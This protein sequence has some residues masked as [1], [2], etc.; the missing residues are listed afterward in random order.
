MTTLSEKALAIRLATITANS[1]IHDAML[2][3]AIDYALRPEALE[4]LE[5][6]IL[7]SAASSLIPTVSSFIPIDLTRISQL[8]PFELRC[9]VWVISFPFRDTMLDVSITDFYK[10]HPLVR[11][12]LPRVREFCGS[13]ASIESPYMSKNSNGSYILVIPIDIPLPQQ[14][15]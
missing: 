4:L 10:G 14:V 9:G 15:D 13:V 8:G 11:A 7:A 1:K 2:N 3:E 5:Q 6:Q 12:A